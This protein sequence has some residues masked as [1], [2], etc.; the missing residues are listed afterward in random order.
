M[1]LHFQG[2]FLD[3]DMSF[4]SISNQTSI[5]QYLKG[6]ILLC[7]SVDILS[8][9]LSNG[10]KL[11][12]GSATHCKAQFERLFE[13]AVSFI[14]I[15]SS[16]PKTID[17]IDLTS[18]IIGC[19]IPATSSSDTNSVISSLTDV[20]LD[21]PLDFV[22]TFLN[23]HTHRTLEQL[24]P[25]SPSTLVGLEVN[26]ALLSST[27]S[28]SLLI[29]QISSI[30]SH[31]LVDI[32]VV[33]ANPYTNYIVQP[34]I[35]WAKSEGIITIAND[36]FRGHPKSPG[37]YLSPSVSR[38]RKSLV[39]SMPIAE[40]MEQFRKCLESCVQM[41]KTY[42]EKVILSVS[43]YSFKQLSSFRINPLT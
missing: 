4:P 2:I 25:H 34:L 24:K 12:Y 3:L 19:S 41:E 43:L 28:S 33:S 7:G 27:V 32:L 39:T 38:Q 23:D 9:S 13:I 29:D 10:T 6:R 21:R 1:L 16:I 30:R 18:M 14:F 5:L 35:S 26:T 31:N 40:G 22:T 11:F 37:L 15:F 20:M 17:E 36:I 42:V 8:R